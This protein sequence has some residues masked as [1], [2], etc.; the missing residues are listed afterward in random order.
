[1]FPSGGQ[2]GGGGTGFG[3]AG[4]QNTGGVGGA[5]GG[6]GQATGGTA[7][8]G[9]G[10]GG[11]AQG[12]AAGSGG[13]GWAAAPTFDT[14]KLVFEAGSTPACVASDCHGLHTENILELALD[15][16]LHNTLLTHMSVACG[17]IPVV[18]PFDPSRSALIRLLKGPCGETPRMPRDC[19]V[20]EFSNTCIPDDYIAAIEEWV[21]IGAPQ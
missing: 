18:T 11:S 1:M 14:V 8:A 7:T 5:V 6:A 4:G 16:R 2:S 17:N 19:I 13:G 12:G 3:G 20:D 21:R 9:A 10:A 15:E